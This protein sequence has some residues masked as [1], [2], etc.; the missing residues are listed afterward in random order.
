MLYPLSYE[1]FATTP[2]CCCPQSLQQAT[3]LGEGEAGGG[4]AVGN[5]CSAR[6]LVAAV[7]RW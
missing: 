4:I 3:P 6:I 7:T 5:V 2:A 1:G